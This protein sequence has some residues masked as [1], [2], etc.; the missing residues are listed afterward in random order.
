MPIGTSDGKLYKDEFDMA[1]EEF[2]RPPITQEMQSSGTLDSSGRITVRPTDPNQPVDLTPWDKRDL[3]G[4]ETPENYKKF[5]DEWRNDPNADQHPALMVQFDPNNP[6]APPSRNKPAMSTDE[7]GKWGEDWGA[8]TVPDH[9]NPGDIN[10]FLRE[11]P[12]GRPYFL[13][14][15]PLGPEMQDYINN[16]P[17]DIEHQHKPDDE[18]LPH[19]FKLKRKAEPLT[20]QNEGDAIPPNARLTSTPGV[21]IPEGSQTGS[22]LSPPSRPAFVDYRDWQEKLQQFREKHFV[23]GPQDSWK[24]EARVLLEGASEALMG[25]GGAGIPRHQHPAAYVRNTLGPEF[26]KEPTGADLSREQFFDRSAALRRDELIL[27][28]KPQGEIPPLDVPPP[29]SR[30]REQYEANRAYINEG[31]QPQARISET[32]WENMSAEERQHEMARAVRSRMNAQQR[33]ALEGIEE[34]LGATRATT[35]LRA[36]EQELG[37]APA[38]FNRNLHPEEARRIREARFRDNSPE[39]NARIRENLLNPETP[40]MASPR[41]TLS[42]ADMSEEQLRGFVNASRRD[43]GLRPYTEAEWTAPRTESWRAHERSRAERE[44][45]EA[46]SRTPTQYKENIE[47]LPL[48]EKKGT[49]LQPT[50]GFKN[51]DNG[52]E[53]YRFRFDTPEGPARLDLTKDRANIHVNYVGR[54]L[55]RGNENIQGTVATRAILRE[56]KQYFP[57]MRSISGYRIGGAQTG[58]PRPKS[59]KIGEE[60][61]TE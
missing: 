13:F 10:K 39:T 38:G 3:P 42:P 23:S 47:H 45:Q 5:M 17:E 20:S 35:S 55:G 44:F 6:L 46:R 26:Q 14:K 48:L 36:A 49:V 52:T 12:T 28:V 58:K 54:G 41:S 53:H 8:I 16:L 56:L 30:A 33:A 7:V 27:G 1:I 25:L 61:V 15:G 59:M 43:L 19:R 2:H 29:G 31:R 24:A 51:T 4:M 57:D 18:F 32:H 22:D 40:S 9:K 37:V 34:S 50:G 21:E 11:S 60:P